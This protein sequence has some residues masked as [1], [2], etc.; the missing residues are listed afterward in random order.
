MAS[1]LWLSLIGLFESLWPEEQRAS[2]TVGPPLNAPLARD[3][4][5]A[6]HWALSLP[7]LPFL[8][9]PIP[10][11]TV[12]HAFD[13]PFD[14]IPVPPKGPHCAR[15]LCPLLGHTTWKSIKA[16]AQSSLTIQFPSTPQLSSPPFVCQVQ[17]IHCDWL[18][19][20]RCLDWKAI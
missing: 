10:G 14:S 11:H 15:G 3:Y 16:R 4:S 13:V 18:L 6:P 9:P 8:L 7:S 19:R 17:S 12:P 1:G 5:M 2:L 20:Q